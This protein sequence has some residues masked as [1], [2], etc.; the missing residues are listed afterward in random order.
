MQILTLAGTVGKDSVLR[1]TERGDDVLGFSLAVSN[2]KDKDPTW[3]DCAIW[4]E[5]ARKLEQ[6][7]K[8]GTKIALYGRPTARAHDGKAYLG[9]NVDNFTFQSSS[10]SSERQGGGGSSDSY[11]SGFSSGG[12]RQVKESYDLNDSIPF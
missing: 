8:K 3:Y 1:S 2:G 7:I 4:G 5:R 12:G 11:D 6:Y 10:Q 9:I